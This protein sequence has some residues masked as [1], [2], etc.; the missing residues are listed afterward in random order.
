MVQKKLGFVQ[1]HNAFTQ[2]DDPVQA[3]CLADRFARLDWPK[4]L[5]GWARQ[6]NPLL[7]E[8]LPGYPVHWVVDQAEYATDLLFQ[9]RAALAGL[10][11]ALVD[12]AV[13]TFTPKDILSFLGRKWDRR[14]D[15][16]VHTEYED[17][18]WFGTRIK[19]RMKTNWLK[20]YDK[21]G[22]ILRVETVI[23]SAKEFWV[24]RTQ[25]HRDGTSSVGYYPMTK[26]VASLVDYQEQ[27]LAC[28]R[29]YLDALA[30]V[31]DPVPAYQ[32]LRPLTEPKVVD[33][34]SYAGFNPARRDDVRLFKAVLDGDHIARGFRNADIREPLFGTSPKRSQQ[35]R[36]SAAVGRL[37]KR[38][39]VRHLVAKIPRTRRWRVTEHGRNLLGRAVQLYYPAWPELAA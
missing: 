22:T 7:S 3:R 18:R 13:R 36:A 15:G 11:R 33:G 5:N 9:S 31:D 20:M 39:H 35:R 6:V 23:N 37:L 17:E 27:A 19:H 26:G 10:Y 14:F 30:V 32:D 29:R 1:Q 28:N 4:I 21:F 16:E 2:L 25:Y 12:Y 38:L 8:L 34:R 24:Y